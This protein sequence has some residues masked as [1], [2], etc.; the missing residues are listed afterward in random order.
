ME[1]NLLSTYENALMVRAR[2]NEVLAANIANADT[3]GYKAR[4]IDFRAALSSAQGS[5]SLPLTTTS[6]LHRQSWGQ[7]N[8]WQADAAYRIPTQP[9]LDGNTVETDVEQAQ[10]AENALQYRAA[11]SFI[12]SQIRSIRYALKGGE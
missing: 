8:V 10:F 12:D 2:R 1:L 4:D 5:G 3:P 6:E 7:G 9:T 11:L